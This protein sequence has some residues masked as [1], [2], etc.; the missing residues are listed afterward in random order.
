MKKVYSF[1]PKGHT[2]K[3]GDHM[4]SKKL[5]QNRKQRKPSKSQI[6]GETELSQNAAILKSN[7]KAHKT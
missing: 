5:H 6:N 4:E 3:R 1:L 7:A 2:K